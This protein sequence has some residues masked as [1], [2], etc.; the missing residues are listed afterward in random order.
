MAPAKVERMLADELEAKGA[1]V[2][3]VADRGQAGADA[4]PQGAV[5]GGGQAGGAVDNKPPVSDAPKATYPTPE[6]YERDKWIYEQRE[7][8]RTIADIRSDLETN[9]HG[10]EP[11]YS[12]NGIREA[13][14]RYAKHSGLPRPKGRPGKPRGR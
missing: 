14:A 3:K 2:A 9:T 5:R 10:W 7:A 12:D 6:N 4:M 8:K 11:L 13:V 1:Q